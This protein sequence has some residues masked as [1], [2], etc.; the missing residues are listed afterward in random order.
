MQSLKHRIE[1]LR[2]RLSEEKLEAIF[3]NGNANVS[4]FT[5]KKGNDCSLYISADEAWIITD[6]RYE[7]MA[8]ELSGWLDFYETD[9]SHKLMDFMKARKEHV[10]AVERD[11]LPLDSYL[12]F[13]GELNCKIVPVSGIVEELRAVKEPEELE[14]IARAE[15]IADKAFTE[16]LGVI[17]P[18]ITEKEIAAELEYRMRRLGG[19]GTS[20]DTIAA[21]GPNTSYPHAV[22][23]D[24]AVQPGDFVTMD[25]GCKFNNYCADMTR[26]VAVGEPTEEMRK[27]YEVVLKAQLACCEQIRAGIT[28]HQGDAIARDIIAQAGYGDRFGHSLG[29]GVGLFIH[30]LPNFRM[31]NQTVIA[32]NT[33]LS[34]EPGIYLAGKFGVRIEDLAI[35]KNDGIINLVSSPKELIIL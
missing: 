1:R 4:F 33:V 20:F 19:E 21:S 2:T 24:R 3:L 16:M 25:Y 6:F 18:G 9:A 23:T 14:W 10:I 27:V 29:H 11:N 28:G 15:S 35:I 13:T 26:T 34:I 31:N 5:G 32:E 8:Q 7:E 30:E 12:K 17:R 22:P